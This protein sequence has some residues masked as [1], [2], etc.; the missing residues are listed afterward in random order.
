MVKLKSITA[1]SAAGADR[2]VGRGVLNRC[3]RESRPRGYKPVRSRETAT[4]L[5]T[6]Q[7]Q[8]EVEAKVQRFPGVVRRL[9]RGKARA[10]ASGSRPRTGRLADAGGGDSR[11]GAITAGP[12]AGRGTLSGERH[13]GGLRPQRLQ[14]LSVEMAEEMYIEQQK[15]PD[16]SDTVA[17]FDNGAVEVRVG[18]GVLL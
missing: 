4:T 1:E 15:R 6:R 14:Q 10:G 16:E 3:G 12:T 2:L 11:R 9:G 18:L 8:V 5:T 13:S 7:Q 17:R